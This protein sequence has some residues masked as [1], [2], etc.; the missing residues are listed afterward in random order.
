MDKVRIRELTSN[1]VE[2]DYR[3]MYMNDFFLA[4]EKTG[5][6]I[7]ATF[8]VTEVL[9][10]LWEAN[11]SCW[12]F[13]SELGISLSRDDSTRTWFSFASTCNLLGLGVQ[14][15][16]EDKS[17]IA[18]SETVRETAS[19]ISFMADVT[20]IHDDMY[21]GKDSVYMHTVSEAVQEEYRDG[22]LKQ[23]PTLVSLQ[24]NIDH[25]I[26]RMANMLHI[27]NHFGGM[28]ELKGKK[29]AMSWAYSPSYGKP[30]SVPQDVIDLIT[31]FGMSVVLAYPEGC[32]VMGDVGEMARRNT[33]A[34]GDSLTKTGDMAKAFAGADIVYPKSWAPFTAMR[35]RIDLYGAGDMNGI[36]KLEK[37][38]LARSANHKD[39]ECTEAL[40]A[41][42]RNGG[43]LYMHCLPAN[44]SGVSCAEG[45]VAASVSDRYRI[46]PYREAGYKPYITAAMITLARKHNP[47]DL[48]FD[49]LEKGGQRCLQGESE[50]TGEG[51][52]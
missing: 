9:H 28:E 49:L 41:S 46:P 16:S 5:D 29:V 24:C 23:R 18:H 8:L 47:A 10:G 43:A 25:P 33:T 52:S 13:D 19:M 34:I 45:E 38:L 31:R 37:E 42:T 14:D 48:L 50:D 35:Q 6:E 26:Q 40:M 21:I 15:L 20:G 36:K 27:I 22:M 7:A 30:L 2:H 12:M 44:I 4:W 1:L 39:W 32:E 11:I 3:H 51:I 17:Q